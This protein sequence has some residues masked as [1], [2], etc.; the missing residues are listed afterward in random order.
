MITTILI[1]LKLFGVVG[2]SWGWVAFIVVIDVLIAAN[3]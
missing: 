3:R 2:L 1:L